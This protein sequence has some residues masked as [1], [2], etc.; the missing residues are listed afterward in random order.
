MKTLLNQVL[1]ESEKCVFYFHLKTWRNFLAS[2]VPPLIQLT[3]LRSATLSCR[4]GLLSTGPLLAQFALTTPASLVSSE[5]TGRLP[6]Q[7][8][9]PLLALPLD[10]PGTHRVHSSSRSLLK[11]LFLMKLE[12]AVK[13][14]NPHSAHTSLPS[15]TFYPAP[16]SPFDLRWGPRRV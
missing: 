6:V 3:G 12:Y 1:G 4:P 14:C 8:L 15:P 13:N 7:A 16:A 5:P 2:P 9:L 11:C 10:I